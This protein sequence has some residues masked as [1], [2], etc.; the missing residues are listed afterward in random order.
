MNIVAGCDNAAISLKNDILA[1]LRESGVPIEDVGCFSPDET[2]N[3]PMIA[4]RVCEKVLSVGGE[5]RGMLFCGTG[6]GMCMTANKFRG[7]RAAVCHDVYSAQRSVLSNN[8]NVLCMGERVIGHELAKVIVKEWI[9]LSF[10]GGPSASKV[11]EIQA[12]EAKNYK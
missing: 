5:T 9:S 8:G 7:I 6:I 12:I 1:L 10:N 4:K 11:A 3:Y 2:T